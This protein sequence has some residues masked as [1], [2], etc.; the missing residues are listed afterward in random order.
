MTNRLVQGITSSDPT[1][2]DVPL[3]ELCHESTFAELWQEVRGLEEFWRH[4]DNLYQRVRALFFLYAIHRFHLIDRPETPFCGPLPFAGHHA[5]LRRR[6]S[7][8]LDIFLAQLQNTGPS[9]PLHSALATVYRELGFETLAAQVRTSVRSTSGNRWMFE[10]KNPSEHPLKVDPRLCRSGGPTPPTL[11]EETPV[12]MDLSHSAWSDIFFLGMDYPEGARVLNTSI[13]LAIRGHG[14]H[15]RPPV[16]TRFRVIDEPVLRLTSIDLECSRDL[17]MIAELFDFGSDYL[18]LLKAGVIASGLVPSGL[19]SH[20]APLD[21]LLERLCGRGRGIELIT[22]VHDIPKGSRLA[23]STN[24]LASLIA[25]TMRATGQTEN[26]EGPLKESERRL[27]AARAILGEWLGGSG[28]GWQDS[29]GLW[30][31]SKLI[32]GQSS[33]PNDPEYGISRGCLLPR[34]HP[35]TEQQAPASSLSAL[36]QSLVLVHGGMAQNVGPILEMVT[37]KYLLRSQPEWQSRQQAQT[38]LDRILNELADGNITGLAHATTKNFREP[39]QTIVPWVNNLYTETLIRRAEDAFGSDFWGFWML[40]GMSGGGMGF[41]FDPRAKDAAQ[42]RLLAIMQATKDELSHAL[43]FAMDPVV[44]D[45]QVNERGTWATL[46]NDRQELPERYWRARKPLL[47]RPERQLAAWTRNE[48]QQ[49]FLVPEAS[50]TELKTLVEALDSQVAATTTTSPAIEQVLDSLG[51][52]QQQHEQVQ[53]QLRSGNI[54]LAKNRLPATVTITDVDDDQLLND[55]DFHDDERARG[56][57]LLRQGGV[58]VLTL[59]AGVGS[60]WTQGAGVVKALHPVVAMAGD[61]RRFLEIHFAKTRRANQQWQ[62]TLPHIV[63]TSHLTYEP[64]AHWCDHVRERD[65]QLWFELSPGRS[66]GLR[67]I[68]M[69]RD[70][71]FLWE[72]QSQA[73]LEEQAQKVRESLQAAWIRWAKD[74]GEGNDY[75]D[76]LPS[77]CLHPVGHWFE[78]PNLLLNGTLHRVLQKRPELGV[79]LLH[80]ID[81]LGAHLDAGLVGRFLAT[82]AAYGFEVIPRWYSD[83]GGGLAKVD[84][85]LRLLEGL[86]FPNEQDEWKLRYYNSMTTWIDIDRMLQMFGL[87]RALLGDPDVVRQAV[88]STS[89]RLPTY[90]TIKEVKKRWGRGHEDVF[91]IAQFEKLWSDVTAL[92]DVPTVFFVVSRQ[93]GQQLKEPGQLDA[94]SRDGSLNAVERLCAF[95]NTANHAD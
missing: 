68:P 83:Q 60:R 87:E 55:R 71:R 30:P 10:I 85:R 13:D 57:R 7:E 50:D 94:W 29:G 52:D 61:Y 78:I 48:L 42:D 28:G 1:I 90:I 23:V 82:E 8:A 5:F 91:P 6:F 77:Q 46:H 26:L 64:I 65:P 89:Q 14:E 63:T 12:R 34:H 19:E 76:N 86:A 9:R 59:A 74:S 22:W 16:E 37:E 84:G 32:V 25:V 35:L 36:E 62:T 79:L 43:P 72:Q 4:S 53:S 47:A 44:Y 17:Q 18:G 69:E 11:S 51:F 39:L 95:P 73:R 93:R 21:E 31:G 15:T 58:G 54:G 27:V 33:G 67:M 45:F 56:E 92:D 66:I 24:L 40:G 81:T 41:L 88:R 80:N 70:L 75:R 49:Y 3:D 2:R 38:L 20:N